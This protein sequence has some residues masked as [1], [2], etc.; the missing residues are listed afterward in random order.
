LE[1]LLL[2]RN[3]QTLVLLQSAEIN[4]ET[5]ITEGLGSGPSVA[6]TRMMVCYN[7]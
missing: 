2:E 3:A 7:K 1:K 4:R 6:M 5:L